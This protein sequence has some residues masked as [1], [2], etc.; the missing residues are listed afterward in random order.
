MMRRAV[1]AEVP[2]CLV[3]IDRPQTSLRTVFQPVVAMQESN[4]A[5]AVIVG[6]EALTR[7]LRPDGHGWDAVELT[8]LSAKPPKSWTAH[9]AAQRWWRPWKLG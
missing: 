7:R 2:G 9:A 5:D 4:A 6:Y 3:S 1:R 8:A